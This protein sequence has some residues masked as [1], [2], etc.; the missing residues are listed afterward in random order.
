M[1]NEIVYPKSF[2]NAEEYCFLKLLLSNDADF[3]SLFRQWEAN[4]VFDDINPATVRLLPLLNN[5]IRSS[6]LNTETTG[7][8]K[9]VYR[10]AWFKNQRLLD[11]LSSSTE[12]LEKASIPVLLLKGSS[13]L[14]NIYKDVGARLM[15]DAD[16]LINPSDAKKAILLMLEGG[17]K[18]SDA[19]FPDVN[20]FDQDSILRLNKGI[21]F[22]NDEGI[23]I[24]MH[25]RLFDFP[26]NINNEKI[27]PFDEVFKY[28]TS[29]EFNNKKYNVMSPE[30][31]LMHV[32]VHGAE[33]NMH[34]TFR[35]ITDTVA[36]IE[37]CD[38]DWV[39]FI[40]NVRKY[41]FEADISIAFTYIL[42]NNFISIPDE[43]ADQLLNLEVSDEAG[44]IYYEKANTVISP[45]KILGGLP[46]FWKIYWKYESRGAF[47]INLFNFIEFLSRACGLENKGRLVPFI[48]L[49]LKRRLIRLMEIFKGLLSFRAS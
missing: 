10:L 2:P 31:I 49:C 38:V 12:L 17:W 7:R 1:K 11:R 6:N 42:E 25:W 3:A 15:S 20:Y 39:K 48:I 8:I 22:V 21:P 35:W 47:P 9:G 23:G 43:F 13:L 24:D 40:D 30:D 26:G 19:N 44:R 37:Q 18:I 29:I 34:R 46:R 4:V 33:G 5:R 45:Y 14:I 16:I 32:I 28:S 41:G 36:I 27:M